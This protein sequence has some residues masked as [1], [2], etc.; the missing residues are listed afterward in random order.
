MKLSRREI[1]V[2][3]VESLILVRIGMLG[4]EALVAVIE[5]L[6]LVRIGILGAGA[7]VAVANCFVNG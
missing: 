6:I 1:A 7:L 4:A 2:A 5:S 3:V